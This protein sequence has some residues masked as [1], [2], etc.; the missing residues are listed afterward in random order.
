MFGS[1]ACDHGSKAGILLLYALSC[2]YIVI[3]GTSDTV[4]FGFVPG[5]GNKPLPMCLKWHTTLNAKGAPRISSRLGESFLNLKPSKKD[6]RAGEK[7]NKNTECASGKCAGNMG[8][9]KAGTCKDVVKHEVG[10]PCKKNSECVTNICA[11]NANGLKTGSCSEVK[12]VA[13]RIQEKAIDFAVSK[14]PEY[15]HKAGDMHD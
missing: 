14:L 1:Y 10:T 13:G 5:A 6:L 7:C 2:A 15:L 3:S 8:G 11:G 9:M 4:S 12:L